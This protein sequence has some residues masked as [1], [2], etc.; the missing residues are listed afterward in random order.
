[1]STEGRLLHHS[2]PDTEPAT[3]KARLPTVDRLTGSTS[4][5]LVP[6]GAGQSA[7]SVGPEQADPSIAA[8]KEES[9][10]CTVGHELGR[11]ACVFVVEVRPHHSAPSATALADSPRADPV[12]ARSSRVQVS[13]RDGTVLPHR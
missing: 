13:V 10:N 12:Q 11:A 2:A 4:K 8:H 3:T 6:T 7:V 9:L 1:M 5:R